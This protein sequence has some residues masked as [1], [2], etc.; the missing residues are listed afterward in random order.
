[1]KRLQRILLAAYFLL[2]VYCCVWIPWHVKQV[3]RYARAEYVRVGYGWL[4]AGPYR[5]PVIVHDPPEKTAGGLEI[6]A[7]EDPRSGEAD[8]TA[9]P[10]FPLMGLR[11]AA[12]TL[13]CT[14]VFQFA[15]ALENGRKAV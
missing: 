4:W 9:T 14:A 13:I 6:I 1:M 3:S 7:E 12:A 5:E 11:F 8:L 2:L 10:D 15:A